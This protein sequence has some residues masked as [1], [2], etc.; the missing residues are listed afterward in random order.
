MAASFIIGVLAKIPWKEIIKYGPVIIDTASNLL[1]RNRSAKIGPA[2]TVEIR[3]ARLEQN[4]KDQAELIK[5]MAERQ[6]VLVRSIQVLN[7]RLK[8]SFLFL[9]ILAIGFIYIL[10]R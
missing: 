5:N 1:S 8:I 3:I 7:E 6:E 4:E 10:F 2:D 9:I